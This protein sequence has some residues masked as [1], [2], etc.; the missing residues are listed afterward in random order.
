VQK[1]DVL[2]DVRAVAGEAV[3]GRVVG[4]RDFD[5]AAAVDRQFNVAATEARVLQKAGTRQGDRIGWNGVA[6]FAREDG[7]R[8]GLPG[9]RVLRILELERIGQ[10]RRK[11]RQA[12]LS[13]VL[14]SARLG[15]PPASNGQG[16]SR[17]SP[18]THAVRT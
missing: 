6:R 18:H 15:E 9:I 12:T 13:A 5:A 1:E 10:R 4:G 14:G 7:A 11:A 16:A 8:T 2:Q 17:K 3:F